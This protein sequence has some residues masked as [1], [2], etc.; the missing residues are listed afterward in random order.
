MQE[1]ETWIVANRLAIIEQESFRH[2]SL[3]NA[4]ESR[5]SFTPLSC[6]LSQS[7][8][9][10]GRDEG[11]KNYLTQGILLS[12]ESYIKTIYLYRVNKGFSLK[13]LDGYWL[14]QIPEGG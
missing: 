6:A 5:N 14:W 7:V 13:F 11:I 2:S 3:F 1:K 4:T 10:D 9:F 12:L 8:L